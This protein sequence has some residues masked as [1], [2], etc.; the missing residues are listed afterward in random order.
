MNRGDGPPLALEAAACWLGT[1]S[2]GQLGAVR[3]SVKALTPPQSLVLEHLVAGETPM[4]V[5]DDGAVQALLM[6]GP[7]TPARRSAGS[8][9]PV[10][11]RSAGP[12]Y[13]TGEQRQQ[14][15]SPGPAGLG[16]HVAE[17]GL[18][19]ANRQ[20]QA[21]GDVGVSQTGGGQP[22]RRYP[23]LLFS[24]ARRTARLRMERCV[25][26]LPRRQGREIAAW[27]RA[28]RSRCHR[29]MVSG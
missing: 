2:P 27:R 25:G 1:Y 20:H 9:P 4:S 16:V 19:G 15:R 3:R 6:R 8:V 13:L 18:D 23:Q 7:G 22:G 26:G 5:D 24:L 28:T 14:R 17:V 10:E 11:P 12:A 29:R 21:G